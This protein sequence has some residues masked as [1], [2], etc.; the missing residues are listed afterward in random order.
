M[1]PPHGPLRAKMPTG[2]EMHTVAPFKPPVLDRD[3]LDAMRAPPDRGDDF[4]D[5]PS[6]GDEGAERPVVGAYP[7]EYERSSSA[8]YY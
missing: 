5:H 2:R 7:A 1:I 3:T 4:G 8:G 6:S